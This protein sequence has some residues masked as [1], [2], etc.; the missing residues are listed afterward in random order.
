MSF[1][2]PA[3]APRTRPSTVNL[4]V[5]LLYAA[6]ALEVINVILG[7]AFA[8]ALQEGAKKAVEGTAQANNNPGQGVSAVVSIIIGVL[9]V[10]LLVLLAIYVGKGKQVARVLTWVLGGIAL[11]CT[12]GVVGFP[13]AGKSFWGQARKNEPALATWDRSNELVYPHHPGW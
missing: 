1:A 5:N 3:P 9:I 7:I 4:A 11:C 2:V 6:A 10:V 12:I 13:V 8:G